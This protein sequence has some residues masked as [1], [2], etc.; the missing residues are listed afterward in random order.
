MPRKYHSRDTELDLFC[1]ISIAKPLFSYFSEFLNKFE[2]FSIF[3]SAYLLQLS[4]QW[5]DITKLQKQSLYVLKVEGFFSMAED[6]QQH[7]GWKNT[8][9]VS[10]SL[11]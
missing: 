1:Q 6:T 9:Q 2:L 3:I 5:A 8:V 11:L 4:T 7:F 10:L